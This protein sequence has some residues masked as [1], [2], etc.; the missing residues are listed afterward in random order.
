MKPNQTFHRTFINSSQLQF[1]RITER[2]QNIF[3]TISNTPNKMNGERP[4][5]SVFI[6]VIEK[7]II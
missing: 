1:I 3:K 7:E 2:F 5:F 4:A 6:N